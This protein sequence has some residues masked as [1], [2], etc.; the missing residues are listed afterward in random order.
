MNRNSP[1]GVFDSGVGGLTVFRQIRNLLPAEDI[2]YFGDTKRTPYGPRS[3]E[4]IKEFTREI[5]SFM[6]QQKIKLAVA[7]C[8][9]ITVNLDDIPKEFDFQIVGMSKGVETAVMSTKT[10]KIGVIATVATINSNKHFEEITASNSTLEV[11]PKA[12]P[13]FAQ[14]VENEQ[15]HGEAVD[16]YAVEYLSSLKAAN[17]DTVILACTHYPFILLAISKVLP[18]IQLID[19]AEE[20][21][22]QVKTVLSQADLLKDKGQ[23][24]NKLYFSADLPRVKRIIANMYDLNKCEYYCIDLPGFVRNEYLR[25]SAGL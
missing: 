19:P 14:L 13:A 9:T 2:I 21:A 7:A 25:R 10:N 17:V 6:K 18:G 23:G 12:C 4:Q 22:R 5:L 1:I 11:F 24:Y 3:V 8:N 15:F 16:R 20:T